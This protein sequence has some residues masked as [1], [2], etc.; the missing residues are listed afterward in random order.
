[1]RNVRFFP[2]VPLL[3]LCLIACS[4]APKTIP[5]TLL[6]SAIA[7]SS[8]ESLPEE[9]FLYEN[10]ELGFSFSVPSR[11]KSENYKIVVSHGN[12]EEDNSE[13]SQVAFYFENDK[14]SPLLVIRCVS[15]AWWSKFS[16][17]SPQSMTFLSERDFD[18]SVFCYSLPS[19][20]LYANEQQEQLYREMM[21]TQEE[22]SACFSLMGEE[23]VSYEEGVVKEA[24]M[25][26]LLLETEDGRLLSFAY[27]KS[28]CTGLQDGL[29]LG[30]TIR[31]G[32]RGSIQGEDTR[33]IT[34]VSLQTISHAASGGKN[35]LLSSEEPTPID[36]P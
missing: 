4:S 21:L 34:V 19:S 18:S 13:Y 14:E 1:M 20:C 5:A 35:V 28:A 17:T 6:E 7:A 32:Y 9:G 8:Q 27:E 23:A 22:V 10:T 30:D 12:Q 2:V 11:W 25:H 36:P 31:V 33:Q 15:S 24:A 26:T 16:E 3:L 29:L